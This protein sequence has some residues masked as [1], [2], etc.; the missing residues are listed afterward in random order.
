M[1]SFGGREVILSFNLAQA[2]VSHVMSF[3]QLSIV[4][5]E[6]MTASVYLWVFDTISIFTTPTNTGRDLPVRIFL[7]FFPEYR[8]IYS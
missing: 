2:T 3:L 7:A 6:D 4:A 5:P 1:E 8:C